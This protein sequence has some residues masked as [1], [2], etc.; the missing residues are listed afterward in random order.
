VWLLNGEMVP[1]LRS[2]PPP[3][4]LGNDRQASRAQARKSGTRAKARG[5]PPSHVDRPNRLSLFRVGGSR[6]AVDHVKKEADQ[7]IPSSTKYE[8]PC[9][10]RP[11]SDDGEGKAD[12]HLGAPNSDSALEIGPLRS[13]R[14]HHVTTRA[15]ITNRSMPQEPGPCKVL[16]TN[17]PMTEGVH[18]PHETNRPR[19]S[20]MAIRRSFSTPMI[21][22][23]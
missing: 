22:T 17:R 3:E 2:R 16:V 13:R 5:Y 7:S 18:L 1:A 6:P 10:G 21:A 20:F 9:K 15:P 8:R 4:G 23:A 11:R 19:V 14:S 12:G